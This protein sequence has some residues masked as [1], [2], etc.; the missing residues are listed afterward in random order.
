MGRKEE[1]EKMEE[2][3]LKY[4][5]LFGLAEEANEE[6]RR[7]MNALPQ[8]SNEIY[9]ISAKLINNYSIPENQKYFALSVRVKK[10]SEEVAELKKRWDDLTELVEAI[11]FKLFLAEGHILMHTKNSKTKRER[12]KKW[13]GN[14]RNCRKGY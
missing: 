2:F 12:Y 3:D 1:G 6:M 14:Y 11:R 10:A 9:S 5:E 4:F 13:H 8:I 7:L